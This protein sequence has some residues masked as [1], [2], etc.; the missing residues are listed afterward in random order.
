MLDKHNLEGI[1]GASPLNHTLLRHGKTLCRASA[2][3]WWP[4]LQAFA[5]GWAL[6]LPLLLYLVVPLAPCCLKSCLCQQARQGRSEELAEPAMVREGG[7][8]ACVCVAPLMSLRRATLVCFVTVPIPVPCARA[9]WAH[10]VAFFLLRGKDTPFAKSRFGDAHWGRKSFPKATSH[11]APNGFPHQ[12][13][14][15]RWWSYLR[16][17]VSSSQK[18]WVGF[19]RCCQKKSSYKRGYL[20]VLT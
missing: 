19:L 4:P 14:N 17:G 10:C 13:M 1:L 18:S 6:Q 16:V 7:W 20:F 5:S 8:C 3:S 11:L 9:C 12:P 2:L 15:N